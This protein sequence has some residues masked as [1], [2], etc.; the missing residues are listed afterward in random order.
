MAKPAISSPFYG[1]YEP[2]DYL[3]QTIETMKD[4]C[5]PYGQ[6]RIANPETGVI[7][8]LILYIIAKDRKTVNANSTQRNSAC[9]FSFIMLQSVPKRCLP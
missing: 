9:M 6:V 8:A 3:K 5:L 1:N 7:V 4:Y 2:H